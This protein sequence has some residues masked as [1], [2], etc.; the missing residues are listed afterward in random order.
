MRHL[1][2]KAMQHGAFRKLDGA[3]ACG[4]VVTESAI[5]QENDAAFGEQAS[6]AC[7]R[8][9]VASHCDIPQQ[10]S[11]TVQ[12]KG[13]AVDGRVVSQDRVVHLD[14]RLDIDVVE[15][16]STVFAALCVDIVFSIDGASRRCVVLS[17]KCI[18]D[19]KSIRSKLQKG[20]GDGTTSDKRPENTKAAFDR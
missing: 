4:R 10:R 2:S 11:D 5:D 16:E 17:K 1:A 18:A 19:L 3:A 7:L 9:T 13:A 15:E 14:R 8:G 12:K 20:H 6:A